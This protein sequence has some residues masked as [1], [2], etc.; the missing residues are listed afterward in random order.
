MKN[1][2]EFEFK[3]LASTTENVLENALSNNIDSSYYLS[4]N[5]MWWSV[6]YFE[7]WSITWMNVLL[8]LWQLGNV[9]FVECAS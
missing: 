9:H 2:N 7:I 1:E 5:G 3:N 6:M 4:V 8:V